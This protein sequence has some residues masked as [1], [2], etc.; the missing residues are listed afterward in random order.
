MCIRDRWSRT[1]PCARG[2]GTRPGPSLR[3]EALEGVGEEGRALP[4]ARPAEVD[5]GAALRGVV[6]GI[7]AGHQ[8]QA[9]GVHPKRQRLAHALV[10][11]A[12]HDQ[13]EAL[14]IGLAQVR[15]AGLLPGELDPGAGTGAAARV[16]DVAQH[17]VCLLYT[18]D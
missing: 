2:P 3:E 17:G 14:R 18:S 5:T 8:D 12:G 11:Q 10:P 9:L 16:G 6:L 13:V 7:E 4:G 1:G 15:E